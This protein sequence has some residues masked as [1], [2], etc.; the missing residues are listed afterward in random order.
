MSFL[1]PDNCLPGLSRLLQNSKYYDLKLLVGRDQHPI[2]VHKNIV[3]T[4]SRYLDKE[5]TPSARISGTEIFKFGVPQ[6]SQATPNGMKEI[7]LPTI[8]KSVMDPI[9]QYIYGGGFDILKRGTSLNLDVLAAAKF[10]QIPDLKRH[11]LAEYIRVFKSKQGVWSHEDVMMIIETCI[12]MAIQESIEFQNG[13]QELLN[14]LLNFIDIHPLL[15]NENFQTCM[16]DPVILKTLV[17]ALLNRKWYCSTCNVDK[18]LRSNTT[19]VC[20]K[21]K[22]I[23]SERGGLSIHRDLGSGEELQSIVKGEPSD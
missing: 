23:L 3:C 13:V 22:E 21:C 4:A 12:R 2:L 5:C 7:R 20:T 17:I 18:T 14:D 15:E 11:I 9:I 19:V 10:L 16:D 6:A 1:N 8:E